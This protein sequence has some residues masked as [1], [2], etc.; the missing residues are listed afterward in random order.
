MEPQPIFIGRRDECAQLQAAMESGH[1]EF[2]AVFGRR[3]VGKTYLVKQF[4]NNQFDFYVTGIYGAS[5]KEQL[6]NF[7][8]RLNEKSRVS[9]AQ[10]ADWWEA[11][12]NLR[13]YLL[14]IKRRQLTVF[15]DEMPWMDT[16]NS[17]F[18]KALELFWNSWAADQPRLK[19][20]V[21]GSATTWMTNKLIGGHGGL[22]NRVT[23]RIHLHPFSL[24]ET[25]EFLSKS[26]FVWNRYII[27][28]LYMIMGG[29]PF[30][31]GLLNKKQTFHQNINRLFFTPQGELATE[32]DILFNSLFKD[33]AA[34]QKVV[35]ALNRKSRGLTRLEIQEITG[36]QGGGL[37]EILRNL[38][39]CD[40]IRRYNAFG[41]RQRGA[42][43]QLVDQYTLF[44]LRFK[45][46]FNSGNPDYWSANMESA[47]HRAWS[48]YAFEQV[49]L[50]H[51]AQIK[52]SLGISG[53]SSEVC[54]WSGDGGQ[55]DLVINRN[56]QVINLCE[57]KYTSAPFKLTKAY[58]EKLTERRELFR[59]QTQTR[60]A[61]HLTIVTTY[62]LAQTQYSEMIPCVVTLDGLFLN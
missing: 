1:A 26:G 8:R 59:E 45:R 13:S 32:Y 3:R 46:E 9:Y 47:S 15:I 37:T 5:I 14:T 48:G 21:C 28:E 42:M 6:A 55:I 51:I 27:T 56:D 36:M 35:E 30:Y 29:V 17:R 7:T 54:S 11:F 49:C 24:A 40:F 33:S 20:V 16:P 10:A 53:V 50:R 19:L 57:M 62:P 34:Y 12:D 44:Y 18:T 25:E 31:L 43:F 23:R 39:N 58:Y 4:F 38:E 52:R 41:K 2:V 61:L 22:H 60:K